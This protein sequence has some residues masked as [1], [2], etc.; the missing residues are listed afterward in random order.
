M[1]ETDRRASKPAR[2]IPEAAAVDLVGVQGII[3]R[4][5][6]DRLGGALTVSL[7]VKGREVELI[8]ERGDLV[9][10]MVWPT[11]IEQRLRKAG[12]A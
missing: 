2:V 11:G 1:S 12:L 6:P 5:E 7:V 3:L 8:R 10:T 4:R 9:D